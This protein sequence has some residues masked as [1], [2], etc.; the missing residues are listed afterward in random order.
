MSRKSKGTNAERE[1]IHLFWNKGFA[2]I[3]AAGSGSSRYPSPDIL[4]GN[5]AR[6]VAI[7]CKT[8]REQVKYITL[9]EV[10]ELKQFSET[11]GAEPWIGMRFKDTEWHFISVEDLKRSGNSFSVSIELIKKKGLTFEEL[12]IGI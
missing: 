11:F 12:T 8:S 3:R 6:R 2:S 9:K 10:T 5:G 4:A 1:L 7:E